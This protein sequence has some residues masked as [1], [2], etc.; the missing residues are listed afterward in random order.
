MKTFIKVLAVTTL[1]LA[2][3][4]V[5]AGW[6]D[7]N[8]QSCM[9]GNNPDALQCE[10]VY[11]KECIEEHEDFTF[12]GWSCEVPDVEEDEPPF[13]QECLD[14]YADYQFSGWSCDD[15]EEESPIIEPEY[16]GYIDDRGYMTVRDVKVEN[17]PGTVEALLF[18]YDESFSF[19][20]KEF[21]YNG[22]KYVI[23]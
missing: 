17:Y 22:E 8:Y 23:E 21:I 6:A 10:E 11:V 7:N 5:M 3:S 14:Y 12:S 9:N 4:T 13:N 1:A 18:S 20:L 19:Q 15:W 2:T 16:C